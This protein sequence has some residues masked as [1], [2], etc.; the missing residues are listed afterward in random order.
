M[1]QLST[2]RPVAL[3]GAVA[4]VLSTG[5]AMA[6]VFWPDRLPAIAQAAIIAFGNSVILT[7]S[8]WWAQRQVTPISQ[9]TLA[10]GTEVSIPGSSDKVVIKATPPGPQGI[11]GG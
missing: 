2:P 4:G 8:I 1:A 9:P 3:S 7:I 11:E 5:I 6:A 10:A